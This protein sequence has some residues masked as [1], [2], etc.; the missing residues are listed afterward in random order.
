MRPALAARRAPSGP[1]QQRAAPHLRRVFCGCTIKK[2]DEK[3]FEKHPNVAVICSPLLARF[4]AF[5]KR[6]YI[7]IPSGLRVSPAQLAAQAVTGTLN[8]TED[9]LWVEEAPA[10]VLPGEVDP[11]SVSS[12]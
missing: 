5:H 6:A 7:C 10:S 11:K 3:T 1:P 2:E 8:L 9:S 4:Y 12:A